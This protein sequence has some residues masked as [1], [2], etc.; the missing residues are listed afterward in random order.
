MAR[1][2]RRLCVAGGAGAA[3]MPQTR[4]PPAAIPAPPITPAGPRPPRTGGRRGGRSRPGAP[5]RSPHQRPWMRGRGSL[6]GRQVAASQMPPSSS[7]RARGPQCN[8][9]AEVCTHALVCVVCS[10][11]DFRGIHDVACVSGLFPPWRKQGWRRAVPGVA[12][13]RHGKRVSESQGLMQDRSARNPL[14]LGAAGHP[15]ILRIAWP[16]QGTDPESWAPRD[17]TP[18]GR[19]E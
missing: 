14:P 1:Q 16:L 10:W 6:R 17:R 12:S 4:W 11:V 19:S 18:G 2:F 3:S 8:L 5:G 15:G 9:A 13:T 7:A